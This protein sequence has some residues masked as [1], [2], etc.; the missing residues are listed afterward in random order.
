MS[1]DIIWLG[2]TLEDL[3]AMPLE[4]KQTLGFALRQLQEGL[5][6]DGATPLTAYGSGVIEVGEDHD[7]N[8]YRSVQVYNLGADIYVLHCFQK[9]SPKGKAISRPDQNTIKARLTE[10]RR[11]ARKGK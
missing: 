5:F 7:G 10:A 11:L 8:T 6:P 9:K 3:S 1:K 4:V 2:S